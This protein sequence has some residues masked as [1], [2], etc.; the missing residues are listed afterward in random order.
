MDCILI[1]GVLSSSVQQPLLHPH[2][3]STARTWKSTLPLSEL[4]SHLHTNLR[5]FYRAFSLAYEQ[6]TVQLLVGPLQHIQ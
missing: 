1:G 6:P 3:E 5:Y 4:S 2:A